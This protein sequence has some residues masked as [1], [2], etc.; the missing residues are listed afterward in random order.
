MRRRGFTLIELLVV[1]A[2]IAILAAILFPVFS[3]A[4]DSARKT[5]CLSNMRQLGLAIA[6]Y[7][8]D[9]DE[10]FPELASGGCWGRAT[11]ANSLWTRQIY[12]YVKNKGV[13]LCPTAL[14]PTGD[15]GRAGM[16]FDASVPVPEDPEANPRGVCAHL[17]DAQRWHIDR[18]LQPIGMNKFFAPYWQCRRNQDPGCQAY[19]DPCSELGLANC[20]AACAS[21]YINHAR[22]REAAKMVVLTD[23]VITCDGGGGYWINVSAPVNALFAISGRHEGHNITFADGHSKW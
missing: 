3:R 14:T 21:Q 11:Q 8:N 4:R 10:Y 15:S 17:P 7:T 12:P 20:D 18:R 19:W 16:R 22:I 6:A 9:Y 23:G 1:I 13:Y 2:I 5:Q